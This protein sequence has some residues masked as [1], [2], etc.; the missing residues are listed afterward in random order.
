MRESRWCAVLE[1]LFVPLAIGLH[2]AGMIGKPKL[3]LLLLGWLSMWLR[4]TGWRQLGL[5]RPASWPRTAV[6][7]VVIGVVYNLLDIF[8]LL[9]LIHRLTGEPL[10][11]EAFDSLRGNVGMLALLILAAWVSA[12]LVEEMLYRGYLLNRATDLFGRS[13]PGWMLSVVLVSIVFAFAHHSQGPSG[14]IDN[15]IAGLL[16]AGLYLAS[17]RN[18]WLPIMVHGVVD[19]SS[20]VLLY[21]GFKP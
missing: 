7:A 5:A 17:R 4:R 9:P 19:T 8:V 3:P 2:A 16:F 21:A 12:A 6:L 15:A 10:R 14:V 13:V 11:L 18:L 20:L 1:L